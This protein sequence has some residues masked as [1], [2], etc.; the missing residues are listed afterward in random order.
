M[1]LYKF[2]SLAN[3]G[4]F[5]RAKSIL[6]TGCFWCENFFNLND[7]VEGVFYLEQRNKDKLGSIFEAKEEYKICSF[8]CKKAFK[9][10]IMWGYYANGF[11]GIAIEIEI[12]KNEVKKINYVPNIPSLEDLMK[13]HSNDC[14]DND[15][16]TKE[17]ISTKLKPW[18]HEAEWRFLK[19]S[20]NNLHKIGEIT[21]VYFGNPRGNISNINDVHK[22][23]AENTQK[24]KE[25][26][27][28]YN[29]LQENLKN[30]AKAKGIECKHVNVEGCIVK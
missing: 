9:N 24:G 1:K 23:E 19:K 11:R 5:N 8:G 12:E 16:I 2:R 30:V 22:A 28:N 7:P 15:K 3:E 18:E 17:I 21:A 13:K 27:A 4:D 6:E 14:D 10:P 20:E 29:K 25:T 26:I